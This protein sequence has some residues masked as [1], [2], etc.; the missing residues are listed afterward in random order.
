MLVWLK[1][2]EDFMGKTRLINCN[3]CQ[4]EKRNF[5]KGVCETCYQRN[6][7]R[8]KHGISLDKPIRKDI[9]CLVNKQCL[10]CNKIKKIK[11]NNL[12]APCFNSTNEG[13]QALLEKKKISSRKSVR[14]KLGI[15]ENSPLLKRP[16]GAGSICKKN[17][18]HILTKKI[19]DKSVTKFVHRIV[20]E[21]HIGRSLKSFETVHHKNGIRNDNRIENLELWHKKHPPGRRVDE[22]I[23]WCKEFL[24][25]YGYLI[26]NLKRP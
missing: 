13:L 21:K 16:R 18:Y 5:S 15:D 17:G 9:I 20:M 7:Y 26:E 8:K 19:N 11:K 3:I 1:S 14:R 6:L 23:Q 24:E 25:E 4:K 12:C 22:Q 2:N 10:N